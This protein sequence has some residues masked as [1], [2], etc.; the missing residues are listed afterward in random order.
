MTVL[1]DATLR[2][3][4]ILLAALGLAAVL[5]HRSAALRHWV[6]AAGLACAAAAP[7]LPLVLP[8]W[9]VTSLAIPTARDET[10]ETATEPS[11]S[12][13]F[14]VDATA[15]STRPA[16]SPAVPEPSPRL[17]S[18]VLLALWLAGVVANLAQLGVG[19]ARAAR[20]GA[21][22]RRLR[23]GPLHDAAE[24]VRAEMGLRRPVDL[25]QSDE[26]TALF[27][28][29]AWRPAIVLPASASD[30]PA[31]RVQS[32][33]RHEF[34]HVA[35]GDWLAQ[36][37]GETV[38]AFCWMSPLAWIAC[39]RLRT[40]AE[41]AC[42]D[43]VLRTGVTPATYASHLLE[44]ARQTSRHGV[45][46]ALAMARP[47]TLEGRILAMLNHRIS[48]APLGWAARVA[49]VLAIAAV[50]VPVALAQGSARSFSGTVLDPMSKGVPEAQVALVEP[51]GTR[52]MAL[53]DQAG[54]FR[55]GDL[56]AQGYTLEVMKPG[57]K[58]VKEPV[59]IGGADVTRTVTLE[60]GTV[61]E[62]IN[63]TGGS[64]G[65]VNAI[66]GPG[67][68]DQARERAQ[69]FRK[70]AG[71]KCAAGS[72]TGGPGG[73][74]DPPKKLIDVKPIASPDLAGTVE[75][76]AVIGADGL[77]HDVRTVATPGPELE[78]AATEAVRQWE[79]SATYLN[80][81]PVS[82]RMHVTI[83]FSAAP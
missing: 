29:G 56:L 50:T 64:K 4:V 83:K 67:S 35:R 76:D 41:R 52:H 34:A 74:I 79:F 26:D 53:T 23:R 42:D 62:S 28:W 22:G 33:L 12:T 2:V 21:S 45:Q 20:A 30:W 47:S 80:C 55:L 59:T 54:R 11:V 7:L 82:V 9:Q 72:P 66:G 6:I 24:A 36:L 25:R 1:L 57:F 65:G 39:A 81:T 43:E 63:V 61:R 71:E 3:S 19:F 16:V 78:R 49:T 31:D 75:L 70:Q 14:V 44:V 17:W 38:R 73:V 13:T 51:G 27:T 68:L 77:V 15:L 10:A 58:A 18:G 8:S 5:S 69:A 46:P 48:R 60:L 40:E 37:L 32:V